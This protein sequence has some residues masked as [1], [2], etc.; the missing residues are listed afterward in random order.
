MHKFLA[1]LLAHLYCLLHPSFSVCYGPDWIGCVD[2]KGMIVVLTYPF[3]L[4]RNENRC[5]GNEE[6]NKRLQ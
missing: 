4:V 3:W 2:K 5:H 6:E 1:R